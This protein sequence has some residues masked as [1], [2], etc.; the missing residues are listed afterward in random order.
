M[1]SVVV[2]STTFC[3]QCRALKNWLNSKN[4][5]FTE[6]NLNNDPAAMQMFADKGWKFVPVTVINHK[7]VVHGF[8][9]AAIESA[10]KLE[11]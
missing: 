10:L 5:D 11:G 6:V 4:I 8:D 3:G 9:T 2:Y 1:E 7:E